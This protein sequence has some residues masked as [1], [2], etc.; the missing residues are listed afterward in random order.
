MAAL[1]KRAAIYSSFIIQKKLE[2]KQKNPGYV[3]GT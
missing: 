1:L 2:L 3:V